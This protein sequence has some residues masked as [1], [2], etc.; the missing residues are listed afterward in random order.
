[1]STSRLPTIGEVQGV[2]V[3][4][5][6][7]LIPK[8]LNNALHIAADKGDFATVNSLISFFDINAKGKYEATVLLKAAYYGHVDI[9]KL[10]LTR[11]PDVNIPDVSAVK[12]FAITFFCLS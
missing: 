6:R 7:S 10:V 12:C 2:I 11:N 8:E 1:M 3:R 5:A 4:T 9:V